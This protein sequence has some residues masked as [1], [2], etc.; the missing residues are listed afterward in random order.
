MSGVLTTFKQE[1]MPE[2]YNVADFVLFPSRYESFGY[3]IVE[4]MSYGVPVITG[5]VSVAKTIYQSEPFRRLL[6]PDFNQ[7]KDII[8]NSCIEKLELLRE[9]EKFRTMVSSEGRELVEKSFNIH[10]WREEISK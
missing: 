9:D 2:L 5:E 6:L 8:I 10:R 4:A 7:P 3:V 1:K